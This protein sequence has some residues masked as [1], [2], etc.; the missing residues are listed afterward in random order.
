M[1]KVLAILLLVL[2]SS[3]TYGQKQDSIKQN[4]TT[5]SVYFIRATGVALMM[6][7][8][9]AFIDDELVCRIDDRRYSVHE[10]KPGKHFLT[11]QAGG[12][13]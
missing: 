6:S 9:S 7:T 3:A 11:I 13:N 12:K 8:F 4:Q 2:V 5:G 10:L 1:N